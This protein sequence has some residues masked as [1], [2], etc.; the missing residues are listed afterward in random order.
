MVRKYIVQWSVICDAENEKEAG[1]ATYNEMRK[2][3]TDPT[4]GQ[5]IVRVSDYVNPSKSSYVHL[6]EA[7]GLYKDKE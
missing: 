1:V 3:I 7:L 6:A 2:L 5:S 4:Y